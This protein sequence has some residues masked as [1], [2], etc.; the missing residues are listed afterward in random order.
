MDQLECH[1]LSRAIAFALILGAVTPV[2]AQDVD[3]GNLGTRG[4]RI[5]GIDVGDGSGTRVS[6]AG[7]VN[8][9]GLADLIIGAIGADPEGYSYAGESYVVFGRADN[10][11]VDL[12]NLGSGGF[13]IDGIDAFDY[14]GL[15]ISGAGDV[16]GD[17]LADLVIG[18]SGADP[19]NTPAA[20]ESYV[21]FG[22]T[23]SVA[24][25]LIGLGAGGFRING[26]NESDRSGY[27]I[28]G[29]GDVNG[30]GLDDLIV[31]APYADPD[32]D[33]YAGESYVVFGKSDI[34]AVNLAN[35]G[36]GGF[37]IEGFD[38]YDCSSFSV[39]G[40]GDV[41]GDGLDDLI[42]GAP[43]AVQGPG[44]YAGE[45][46]VVFG[47]PD[48]TAVNLANLGTSGFRIVGIAGG[49]YSGRSV[50]G[51]GDVNGDGLADLI[52]GAWYADSGGQSDAGESYLVF[53]KTDSN[54]V[55]LSSLGTSGFRIGGST[56]G[57]LLG[58]SVSG[59]GDVNG[60]GLADLIVGA[61]ST[62]NGGDV[63]VGESYV[64]FGKTSV[65]PVDVLALGSSGFRIAGA[66][67]YD[68]S[69][70]SVSG[71]GDV[72]GDGLADLVVGAPDA[73]PN[74]NG[75]AGESYVVFSAS[76]PPL[77]ASVVARSA[78]GNPSR[79]A[80]GI[81]G[82]GSNHGTPDAR[83]WIDFVDGADPTESASSEA[84]ELTRSPG[85]FPNA[86]ANVSWRLQSTRQNWSGAEL[87]LR[88][89]DSE[90]VASESL[91][92][93]FYSPDGDVSFTP[94]VSVVNPQENSIA[95][96]IIQTG[97]YFIGARPDLIF[98]NDFE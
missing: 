49:D 74:G 47:K 58:N 76:E 14:S 87:R 5:D 98:V 23:D 15:A 51:A 10:A 60:D 8:G 4:F 82:D 16:N 52:V 34:A 36:T 7:D 30:D 80:F 66:D 56:A 44:G 90:L 42:V 45:S 21:V 85:A 17:G 93:I 29:A 62:S 57:S 64:V 13:R 65:S 9:D 95:A 78:N 48:N 2:A 6:G 68:L 50:S 18:A 38:A 1:C 84:I 73:D 70:I 92:Q 83:A 11:P 19:Y 32:G 37:P 75:S 33:D 28:S 53:G 35:L 20:G 27:S 69:G 22:K 24:V 86:G 71:A 96:T 25:E 26:I 97:F 40:A 81:T 55:D 43:K 46:Y 39:S 88:Y 94:L 89:L 31:G 79:T 72:N 3:L 59:A 54:P 77:S 61:H 63:E 12:A 91:L 41:N 67:A